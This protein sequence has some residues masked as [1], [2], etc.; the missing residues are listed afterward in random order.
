MA[1]A[2]KEPVAKEP[3]PKEH[4][5]FRHAARLASPEFAEQEVFV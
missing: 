3:A 1:P 2:P 4:S 5:V